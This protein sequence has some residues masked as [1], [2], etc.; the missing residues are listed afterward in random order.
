VLQLRGVVFNWRDDEAMQLKHGLIAQE[1]Q[2]VVPELVFENDGFL[3]VNYSE[4]A[5]L[6]VEAIKDLK[7]ETEQL[8]IQH[9]EILTQLKTMQQFL[10]TRP[11][12]SPNTISTISN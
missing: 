9:Q 10:N 2:D 5:G 7:D 8:R 11:L 6:F 12:I 3:G 4:M 1:V